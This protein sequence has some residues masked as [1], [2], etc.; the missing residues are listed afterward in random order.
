MPRFHGLRVS[1]DSRAAPRRRSPTGFSVTAAPGPTAAEKPPQQSRDGGGGR[2]YRGPVCSGAAGPAAEDFRRPRSISSPSSLAGYFVPEMN[3]KE[4]EI[5]SVGPAG[6]ME[7]LQ[8]IYS[9]SSPWAENVTSPSQQAVEQAS[10]P[11]NGGAEAPRFEQ[12]VRGG[13]REEEDGHEDNHKQQESRFFSLKDA[14]H[15]R[16]MTAPP[17]GRNNSNVSSTPSEPMDIPGARSNGGESS[18]ANEEE[19]QQEGWVS[20]WNTY[21]RLF[22]GTYSGCSPPS[23]EPPPDSPLYAPSP[24][25]NAS[26][27]VNTSASSRLPSK[28]GNGAVGAGAAAAAVTAPAKEVGTDA[29]SGYACSFVTATATA[30]T[31]RTPPAHSGRSCFPSTTAAGHEDVGGLAYATSVAPTSRLGGGGGGGGDSG[32]GNRI[33][34]ALPVLVASPAVTEAAPVAVS[35][36]RR[37]SSCQRAQRQHQQ[38]GKAEDEE[39]GQGELVGGG[40]GGDGPPPKGYSWDQLSRMPL[41][42]AG[43]KLGTFSAKGFSAGGGEDRRGVEGEEVSGENDPGNDDF[44]DFDGADADMDSSEVL[45]FELEM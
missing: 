15:R 44:E 8:S 28:P 14:N 36:S 13:R 40:E 35:L 39:Q 17:L 38:Q 7:N 45:M 30:T 41:E 11:R 9:L 33:G 26:T 29:G 1:C 10:L 2:D 23:S 25:K 5:G 22:P 43:K 32:L 19:E 12:E 37:S 3:L 21:T 16:S 31:A 34:Q 20:L 4:S 18:S 42:E 24:P 27:R 6:S